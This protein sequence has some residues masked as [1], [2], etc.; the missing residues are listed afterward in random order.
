M[1][2][3]IVRVFENEAHGP[4]WAEDAWQRLQNAALAVAMVPGWA[5]SFH[6]ESDASGARFVRVRMH[7]F[8][9][10][11]AAALMAAAGYRMELES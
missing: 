9:F 2:K 7:G 3:E 4:D 11:E 10:A 6:V 5:Q 8:E 1:A